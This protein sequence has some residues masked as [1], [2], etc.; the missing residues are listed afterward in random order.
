MS[1]IVGCQNCKKE[2]TRNWSW[3]MCDQCYFRICRNCL[4]KHTGKYALNGGFK[5]SQCE[6]GRLQVTELILT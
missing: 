4:N 1:Y 5:C 6:T 3:M 2:Y